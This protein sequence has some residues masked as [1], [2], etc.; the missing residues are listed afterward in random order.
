MMR[1]ALRPPQAILLAVTP[2]DTQRWEFETL[3]QT[4]LESLEL[5]HLRALDPQALAEDVLV[6]RALPAL[7]VSLNLAGETISTDFRKAIR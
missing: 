4:L 2:P 6:Q 1:R 3:E 5:A 7:Y